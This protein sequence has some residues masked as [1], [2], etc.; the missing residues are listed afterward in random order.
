[1]GA[2]LVVTKMS[3]LAL[4]ITTA[5]GVPRLAVLHTLAIVRVEVGGGELDG[6]IGPLQ[7][8]VRTAFAFAIA[9]VTTAATAATAATTSRTITR[10]TRRAGRGALVRGLSSL[11]DLMSENALAPTAEEI[12]VIT[13][14]TQRNGVAVEINVVPKSVK[15]Q[16][17]IEVI[18]N[19][20]LLNMPEE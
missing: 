7:D 10:V 6:L 9:L 11:A 2:F 4:R 1:M 18:L 12:K 20:G 15:R 3:L 16:I 17:R 14:H 13:T 5:R 19:E 8:R